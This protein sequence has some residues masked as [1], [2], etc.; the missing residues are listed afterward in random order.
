M[1][2]IVVGIVIMVFVGVGLALHFG[3]HIKDKTHNLQEK[4]DKKYNR[5]GDEKIEIQ[6]ASCDQLTVI[7]LNDDKEYLE[8]SEEMAKKH[9][10]VKCLWEHLP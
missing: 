8:S 9:Y 2:L 3:E 7:Y 5:H 4:I 6:N 1:W 10:E